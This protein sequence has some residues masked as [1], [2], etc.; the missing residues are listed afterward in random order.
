MRQTVSRRPGGS[1]WSALAVAAALTGGTALLPEAAAGTLQFT[2]NAPDLMHFFPNAQDTAMPAYYAGMQG[3]PPTL[4][5]SIAHYVQQ[6]LDRDGLTAQA[7][8]TVAAGVATVTIA[9]SDAAAL[10]KAQGYFPMLSA[11][12]DQNHAELGWQGTQQCQQT[13]GCWNP[14]PGSAPW[15]FYLPLGLPLV[16]QQAVMFLNY[17]PSDSLCSADYLSNFTMARWTQVLTRVGVPNPVL[18]ETIVDL[19]PIAA[20]G[21]GQSTPI[22]NASA[23]FSQGQPNYDL[24]MLNLLLNPS[25]G[26]SAASTLPL[27]V[28]GGPS[29]AAWSAIIGQSVNVGEV[30]VYQPAAGQPAI[31]WVATNHPDV[32]TY[33]SCPGD[34]NETQLIA[35]ELL[36]LNA[37]CILQTLAANPALTPQQAQGQCNQVWCADDNG[38]CNVQALCVQARM[39]YS[40]T[41]AGNCQCPAAA[42]QFCAANGNNACPTSTGVVSCAPYNGVCPKQPG[43][44]TCASLAPA[45]KLKQ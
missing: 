13:A 3:F 9:S 14:S 29:R 33:Q 44:S 25:G 6:S 16:N 17:P 42:E 43:Y 28:A 24:S 38:S 20:P 15:A 32:T 2:L 7:S 37:A 22:A 26:A 11:L 5:A 35:N 4:A 21:S 1:L 19:N 34:G 30:G 10:A 12:V 27:Q 45:N 41:S 8:A 36:D 18:F 23:N 40:F 39:D 31:P